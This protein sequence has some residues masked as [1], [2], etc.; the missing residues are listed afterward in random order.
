MNVRSPL[1]VSRRS[2][3][4]RQAG[5]TDRVSMHMRPKRACH[6]FAIRA[7]TKGLRLTMHWFSLDDSS[8]SL[9]QNRVLFF[10]YRFALVLAKYRGVFITGCITFYTMY[11]MFAGL[12][13]DVMCYLLNSL[14]NRLYDGFFEI[15]LGFFYTQ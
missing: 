7:R 3:L 9:A 4:H 15:V 14:F 1:T 13:T 8:R 6:E 10:P 5:R 2:G 12:V 11:R